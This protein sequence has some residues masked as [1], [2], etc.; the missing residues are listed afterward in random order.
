MSHPLLCP[1]Q[2]LAITARRLCTAAVYDITESRAWREQAQGE[3]QPAWRPGVCTDRLFTWQSTE[4]LEELVNLE[5]LWLGKNKI[6]KLEV[7]SN[8]ETPKRPEHLLIDTFLL[9]AM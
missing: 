8:I 5:E 7:R 9:C 3:C 4:H 2:N 1:K 6:T